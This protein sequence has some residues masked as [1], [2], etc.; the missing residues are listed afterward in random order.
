LTTAPGTEAAE[1][2][3]YLAPMTTALSAKL[4]E[5]AWDYKEFKQAPT[6]T[7]VVIHGILLEATSNEEDSRYTVMTESLFLGQ[8]VNISSA[9]FLQKDPKIRETK[10]YTPM[11]LSLPTDDVEKIT[12]SV[13]LL[14]RHKSS[15]VMWHSNPTKQCRKCYLYRHPEEGC[16]ASKHTCPI[17]AGEHR[18]KELSQSYCETRMQQATT[19]AIF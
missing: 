13:L 18:L 11:V 5:A 14:G 3:N 15:A 16:K 12:P 2:T 6:D 9:R 8:Q 17:S 1:Y 4:P 7:Q 19:V 10:C